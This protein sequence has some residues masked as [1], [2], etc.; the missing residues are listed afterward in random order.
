MRARFGS[1]LGRLLRRLERAAPSSEGRADLGEAG[2]RER[3]R[4]VELHRLLEAL[5][6]ALEVELRLLGVGQGDLR[7]GRLRG[8][9]DGLAGRRE[10]RVGTVRRHLDDR[11]EGEGV[12]VVRVRLQGLVEVLARVLHAAGG[13]PG[14]R[15]LGGALGRARRAGLRGED[16][17]VVERPLDGVERARPQGDR[18]R[19]SLAGHGHLAGLEVAAPGVGL[20]VNPSL[21]DGQLGLVAVARDR[22]AQLRA[23]DRGDGAAAR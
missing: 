2:P 1:R 19:A 9:G 11:L 15:A 22:E 17:R 5:A 8:G 16:G 10:G 20:R 7:G 6:R 21:Q 3:V 13:E 23:A 14:G 4:R 12:G 18:G